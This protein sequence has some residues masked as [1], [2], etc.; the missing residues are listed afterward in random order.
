VVGSGGTGLAFSLASLLNGRIG[1]VRMSIVTYV[2]PLVAVALGVLVRDEQISV[3]ALVGTLV[4]LSG[5][6]LTSRVD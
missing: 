3:W 6:Y 5:A 2:I 1:A 4:A